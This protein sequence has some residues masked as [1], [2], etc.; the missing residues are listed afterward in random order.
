[1]STTILYRGK[2]DLF[3]GAK[4]RI[5]RMITDKRIDE[6]VYGLYGIRKSL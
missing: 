4:E 1:M 3:F 2:G 5:Q 6:I